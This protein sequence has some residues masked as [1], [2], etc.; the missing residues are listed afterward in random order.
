MTAEGTEPLPCF[1]CGER[2]KVES[3][4]LMDLRHLGWTCLCPSRCFETGAYYERE[5]AVGEWN[6]WVENEGLTDP[7]DEEQ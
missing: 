7:S 2:P 1:V 3:F 5:G 4:L 6:A